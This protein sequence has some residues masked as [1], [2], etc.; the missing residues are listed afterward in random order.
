MVR[1]SL[2]RAGMLLGGCVLF[3]AGAASANP[4]LI[5]AD[6]NQQQVDRHLASIEIN[7]ELQVFVQLDEASVAAYNIAAMEAT[8][9]MPEPAAQIAQ[10]ERVSA[11]QAGIRGQLI[12]LG[13]TEHSAMR[14]GANGLRVSVPRSALTAIRA[15]PGVVSVAPVAVHRPSHFNSVPWINAPQ[16]WEAF[17]TGEGVSIGIID[18]GIDYLHANFGGSGDPAEYAANDETVIEPGSFPTAK[19]VGGFD[20][21]GDDYNGGNTPMPD[22]DPLDCNGHGSHVAGSAAGLGFADVIGPGVAPGADLYALRVFGCNGSTRV[23]ADAIEWSMDPNGDGDMSD[24]LDVIN[25]S[26]GSDAGYPNEASSIASANAAAIGIIVVASAGNASNVPYIHGSPAVTDEAISVAAFTSGGLVPAIEFSGDLTGSAESTEGTSPVRVADGT[27]SGTLAIPGVNPATGVRDGCNAFTEDMTGQVALISRGACAFATKSDNAAAQGAIGMVVYNDGTTADRILPIV[28]GGLDSATIPSVM[29]ASFVGQSVNGAIEDGAVISV[30]MD[31]SLLTETEFGD[32]IAG[33]S[34]RG[35][36]ALLN[37]FKPDLGGPGVAITSALVGS[38]VGPLTISGTSMAAPHVAGVSA[39]LRQVRP[40][41]SPRAV[42]AILQNTTVDSNPF[43][44]LSGPFPLTRGGVGRVDAYNATTATAFAVPAGI[45]FGRVNPVLSPR[46]YVENLRLVSLEGTGRNFSVTHIPNQTVPGVT[47]E[48]GAGGVL[49]GVRWNGGLQT[50]IR[51]TTNSAEMPIDFGGL[52]QTEV[53]GWCVYDDGEE[54]LRVGYMA[55]VDAAAQVTARA[56][57]NLKVRIS[58]VGEAVGF[59]EAFSYTGG[60]GAPLNGVNNA[61]A[62]TGFRSSRFLDAFDVMEIAVATEA[63]WD[64]LINHEFNMFIDSNFD[65]T[66]E[67]L[68]VGADLGI[69]TGAA[70]PSGEMVTAQFDLVNGGAFLDWFASVADF[71]D[72]VMALPFSKTNSGGLVPDR[73]AY[74]LQMFGRF[75][76]PDVQTG[77]IDVN[78]EVVANLP[79]F[80]LAAGGSGQLRANRPGEMLMLFET[81]RAP[82]QFGVVE[83][84]R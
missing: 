67:V 63:P 30:L 37:A 79:S 23:T 25:M 70:D 83:V 72:H 43:N 48:C 26:L 64:S 66:P 34:S 71:N 68:L 22:A 56:T 62:A 55:V 45:S 81:N 60:Q 36:G 4:G 1:R 35:P 44:T 75:G 84:V 20:F 21:V 31:A 18:T 65:G 10:A 24:H 15:L 46:S 82:H 49:P 6:L 40:D 17:G 39:L 28:M 27:V 69:L 38:G 58:N 54:A 5:R 57:R 76:T 42:K 41:I 53:D 59:G 80:G 47:V 9:S 2:Y 3:L 12:A 51:L 29:V 77:V 61:I 8:G 74:E 52:S 13:A 33:F 7:A 19:V 50:Q 78:R 14:V 11:Q 32:T 16:V 73:F